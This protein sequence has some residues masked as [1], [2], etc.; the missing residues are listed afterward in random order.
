MTK[1]LMVRCYLLCLLTLALCC[2][3]G[4]VWADS[5][6]TSDALIKTSTV[7]VPSL[8]RRAI[9]ADGDWLVWNV[10]QEEENEEEVAEP[11]VVST[12]PGGLRSSPSSTSINTG[13]SGGGADRHDPN[14]VQ[15]QD[16]VQVLSQQK[17][18]AEENRQLGGDAGHNRQTNDINPSVNSRVNGQ[19]SD[20]L[21][22]VSPSALGGQQPVSP[23]PEPDPNGPKVSSEHSS[24][25]RH[26]E[27]STKDD[28]ALH[29]AM[30]SR[31][32]QQ[33][34]TNTHDKQG[35]ET[36]DTSMPETSVGQETSVTVPQNTPEE[37]SS[38]SATP[39]AGESGDAQNES[40]NTQNADVGSGNSSTTT[41]TTTTTTLPPELPNNKKGDAD[42][43]SSISSSLCVRVSLLIVVT[44]ACILVC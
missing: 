30:K 20:T 32:K 14:K 34:G 22:A 35:G 12:D 13:L 11:N 29:H 1:A 17:P 3:C 25:E 4:L 15:T 39:N 24:K 8:V 6:K 38:T 31:E 23:S 43:S 2:A 41:T 37:S 7:G 44:L 28:H 5:P 42:S 33:E 27:A 36:A 16:G 26:V 9:P 18:L 19:V 21:S 10:D 40:T